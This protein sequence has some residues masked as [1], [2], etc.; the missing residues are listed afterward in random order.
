[1]IIISP[2]DPPDRRGGARGVIGVA[3]TR[4]GEKQRKRKQRARKYEE[5][6]KFI[7]VLDMETD[8]FDNQSKSKIHPFLCILY[9]ENFDPIIIWEE[10]FE[11]FLDAVIAAIE[12]LPG[13]Y[14][15][16]AHNGGKFD[17]LF[18]V[19]RLRG[20]VSF[21]GRGIMCARI[22]KHELRD[23]FHIIPEKLANFQ[24]DKFDYTCLEKSKRANYKQQIIDYCL[25]DCRYLLDIVKSFV[26]QFGLKL[27]IG[28]AAIARIREHYE[29]KNFSSSWDKMIRQYYFGGRVECIQGAGLFNGPLSLIDV[30]SLYPHVMA[31]YE[32]P[33]GDFHDYE[34]RQGPPGNDTV[35]VRLW[36]RNK[37]A[38]IKRNELGETVATELEGEFRTTIWEYE[39]A[40]RH[41][42][43][44]D[45]HVIASIDCANRTNFSKFV[46]PLYEN[47]ITTKRELARMK[48]VGME[49][50]TA[51]IDMK[52]DDIFYKLLLNNGYGKFAQDPTRY[53]KYYITDPGQMPPPVWWSTIYAMDDENEM[54]K[55]VQPRFQS[56]LYWVWVKPDPGF[57]YRNVGT[58]ASITGAARAVLLN[59]LH[60]AID[61]IYCDTDSIICR[62][63]DDNLCIDKSALGAWDLED[64]FT[65]V[66]VAGK[67]L[68]GVWHKTP[69][70]RTA[71]EL[72][73]GLARE[74]TIKSKGVSGLTWRDLE[75]MLGG[76]A[77][78]TINRG[79]TLDRYGA[80]R[81]IER[82]I[83]VTTR[84]NLEQFLEREA[85]GYTS[86]AG[87]GRLC[88]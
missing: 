86:D 62:G 63:W 56:D 19:S 54:A 66:I 82:D 7:A 24:K 39:A 12:G 5:R 83:R 15:I 21:K 25:A 65:K 85:N 38:L 58:A 8:P 51:F 60:H 14:T 29:V 2:P 33:I 79:V 53:K 73:N 36:C 76:T 4:E 48:A 52:K 71:E 37:G 6:K 40:L 78:H 64:E 30:N 16:F 55:Y 44:S 34:I 87:V 18:L 47:R 67:K 28:Q 11:R 26:D 32:H 20:E 27:S 31:A 69:K 49:G 88:V 61:P 75:D 84:L 46:L 13:A 68:Y 17:Y 57:R 80:Q 42:L 72:K 41:G 9:S 23:S 81:Y 43:I 59:A 50:T 74:Y 22:G 45:V 77:K 1:M 35:F 70:N 3:H 10:N